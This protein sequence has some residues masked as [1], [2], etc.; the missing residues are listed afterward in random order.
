MFDWF[1][2][3]A[4]LLH[5]KSEST[6]IVQR[7]VQLLSNTLSQA[8][9]V[10]TGLKIINMEGQGFAFCVKRLFSDLPMNYS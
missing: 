1:N 5:L 3:A 6:N 10:D 9:T 4:I 7:A 2:S 8:A